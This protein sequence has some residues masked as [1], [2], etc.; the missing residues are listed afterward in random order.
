MSLTVSVCVSSAILGVSS[1]E[2]TVDT[3]GDSLMN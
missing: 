2:K 3:V 1:I